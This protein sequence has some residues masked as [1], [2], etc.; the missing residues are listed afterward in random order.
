MKL[1]KRDKPLK[2]IPFIGLLAVVAM[3][4]WL[5][6]G[7]GN[8]Q[9]PVEEKIFELEEQLYIEKDANSK[10]AYHIEMLEEELKVA[11]EQLEEK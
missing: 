8:A 9:D 1:V 5:S 6:I 7:E 4:S 3:W 2:G 10:M 11:K